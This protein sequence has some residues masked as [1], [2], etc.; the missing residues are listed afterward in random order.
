[1]PYRRYRGPR[2]RPTI[3][4]R[5][6]H[7]DRDRPQ[8]SPLPLREIHHGRRIE[9]RLGQI[10]IRRR[11]QRGLLIQTATV[12]FDRLTVRGNPCGLVC[13]RSTALLVSHRLSV[14]EWFEILPFDDVGRDRWLVR[15]DRNLSD[16]GDEPRSLVLN[17]RKP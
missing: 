11:S 4:H 2:W 10:G 13:K 9:R 1:M 3:A 5:R 7:R 17:L 14:G 6:A 15:W 12:A 8:C 16:A